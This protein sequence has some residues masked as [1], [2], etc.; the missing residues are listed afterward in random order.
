MSDLSFHPALLGADTTDLQSSGAS[1]I[2]DA[3][4]KGLPAAAISG[5]MSVYNT[6][7]SV[8]GQEITD[9]GAT[10]RKYD[11]GMANYYDE[12][13]AGVD[14]LGFMATAIIPGT[15]GMK[16]LKLAQAGE[17]TG[18][19]GRGL[20][21]AG[22]RRGEYVREAMSQLAQSGGTITKQVNSAKWKAFGFSVADQALQASAFELAVAATMNQSPVFEDQ[23]G[24]SSFAWNVALGA[25]VGGV[26]G[27]ALE[28]FATRGLLTQFQGKIQLARREFDTL[29]AAAATK[30][31]SGNDVQ[32]FAENLVNLADDFHDLSF[33]YKEV[34]TGK[35]RT[36]VFPTAEA[37]KQVSGNANKLALEQM[38]LKFN[39]L[40]GGNELVGQSYFG[41]VSKII[42][43]GK[44]AGKLPDD[45]AAD[46]SG[47]L[48]NVK[49][50]RHINPAEQGAEGSV[51]FFVNKSPKDASDLF[52]SARN[53][54][55]TKQ[56]Y[57]LSGNDASKITSRVVDSIEVGNPEMLAA[58]KEGADVITTTD[59]RL[60]VNP[61]SKLVRKGK[62]EG[63]RTTFFANIEKGHLETDNV[64]VH[65]ADTMRGLNDFKAYPTEIWINKRKYVQPETLESSVATKALQSSARYMWAT[66]LETSWFKNR[67]VDIND[68]P[69][70]ERLL[71]SELG[72]DLQSSVQIKLT[73]GNIEPLSDLVDLRRYVQEA[74]L[75][76]LE[77]ELADAGTTTKTLITGDE[78]VTKGYDTRQMASAL[79]VTQDWIEKAIARGFR[80]DT[81][82]AGEEGV[83]KLGSYFKPKNVAVDFDT[84]R[85]Q[86]VNALGARASITPAVGPVPGPSHWATAQLSHQYELK[87]GTQQ[88]ENASRA[89]LGD[90]ASKFPTAAEDLGKLTSE[91]GSG[92]KSLSASN[93]SYGQRAELFSQEVGKQLTLVMQKWRDAAVEMLSF[94]I[95][96]VRD[97]DFASAEL[98]ILTTAFRRDAQKY[99]LRSEPIADT[100]GVIR[101]AR[102][103]TA[104]DKDA[105]QLVIS[106][107][108]ADLDEAIEFLQS[109]GRRGAYDIK[110]QAV[111]EFLEQHVN[112]N[113]AR[114]DKLRPLYAAAGQTRTVESGLVYIPPVDTRRYNHFAFV[115]PKERFGNDSVVSMITAKDADQLRALAATVPD[116]HNVVY[117]GNTENYFKAKGQYDYDAGLNESKINSELRRSGALGDFHPETRGQNVL[118]DY[119]RWHGTQ[120][121]NVA[122]RA[123][124][125]KYRQYTSE[126][127][128]L[129]DQYTLAD[130][131]VFAGKVA[132]LEKRIA[133]PFQ[134]YKKTMLAL[135]KQSEFP[136][137]D[138][139]NEFVDRIGKTAYQKIDAL[140]DQKS[141]LID[142]A[143]A[144]EIATEHGLGSPYTGVEQYLTANAK[145]PKNAIALAFKAV[146]GALAATTLRMD[147]ANS[148]INTISTPIM[149]GTEMAS[150]RNLAKNDPELVGKLAELT[151]VTV[152]GQA[153]Q[154]MPST[155]KL[156][157]KAIWNFFG[158]D[159]DALLKR[160][161][162]NGDIKTDMRQYFDALD[163]LAFKPT[164][165]PNKLMD[166][167]SAGV[168]KMAKITGNNFA[169]QLT[170]FVSADVMRQLSEP[171]VTAGRL[172]LQEQNSYI[173]SFVNRVQ[174]NYISSQRP[175]IFQG[176]TG[177]AVGLFQTYAFNV[178]QQLL[179]HVENRDQ[180]A[181]W[182]FAGLQS[183]VYGL[184]GL[185]FFDAINTHLIGQMAAGNPEHRDAYTAA[186]GFNHELG[187]WLLYGTASAF[188]LFGD[189]SPALYTRGD[190]NPR[191][192]TILPILP[193]D[194]PAVSAS[195]KL[196]N[197][198]K[199]FGKTVAG[200][201][202]TG[203]AMLQ[204]LEHQGWNRPLAGFAQVIAGQTTTSKGS[205]ISSAN[206]METTAMLSNIPER[207]FSV[208]GAS[209]LLGAR[210]MD[211]AVALNQYYR[212]KTYDAA[213][214]ARIADVGQAVKTKL[215]NN[216]M[217]DDGEMQKFMHD[218]ATSGGRIET[219]S[220]SL[221][222]WSKDANMSV[223]NQM[224]DKMQSPSGR[225]MR[226][227]M[228]DGEGL[229][230]NR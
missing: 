172:S 142:F 72:S 92:A 15:L 170:R 39:E 188:P 20:G 81:E 109:Q 179:R 47:W 223:V 19:I 130:K 61:A 96:A 2:T 59:G 1:P 102:K 12:H 134:D 118:E 181:L 55:T 48:Q 135:S 219:F 150:I 85:S 16:A 87:I 49:Q 89:V 158:K 147:F 113:D 29:D 51:A 44:T 217:P 114:L 152:P 7:E 86:L 10:I 56:A 17:M 171:L 183:S 187:N 30:V 35:S 122:R 225:N 145:Y 79:G 95:N 160:F 37:F 184:N 104:Y 176:T 6:Y 9:I 107:Q 189:K 93:A 99:K 196:F 76:K 31:K 64:V 36:D 40:A 53:A 203:Q 110:S 191:N 210:P 159:K 13:K 68:F 63:L 5:L 121:E 8:T 27:G 144:N 146:N 149:I 224:R 133:D 108:A 198:V 124:E 230:D 74:K 200:G 129:S 138:S 34:G 211:E 190:I 206:D 126:L 165:A 208:Q 180:K 46:V 173:S 57:Y 67:V 111:G 38:A 21:Y 205:L 228:G 195:I 221:Q 50:V 161:E 157:G 175:V 75:Q 78:V 141:G 4:T 84:E 153:G 28:H 73:N 58:F 52:V 62:D 163:D 209:R 80:A 100:D 94:N 45:I 139:L 151:S 23:Q 197:T 192:L 115:V 60:V 77:S 168:E 32:M 120:E 88:R 125:V 207:L 71:Q 166:S 229:E 155:S 24:L 213:D 204:A 131:S 33:T 169:E 162:Q 65:A 97:N 127:Q 22:T 193:W 140:R 18:A 201:G 26:I 212:M 42:T 167:M 185:P 132:L 214:R 182:T 128:F 226:M 82:L 164:A 220:S 54:D 186:A 222:R 112:L 154:S 43:D 123:V 136:L 3:I 137:L 178:L 215:Y 148:I 91:A 103:F 174:G 90:D 227:L 11:S 66:K 156:I 98:G 25:G 14:T 70:V 218:Y 177:A 117:K 143:K 119:V 199:T 202:D 41:L 116:S 101:N 105:D 194:I 216:Q 106:R 83:A 69:V